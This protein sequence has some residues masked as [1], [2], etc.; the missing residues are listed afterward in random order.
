M[1]EELTILVCDVCD[2]QFPDNE[3]GSAK[4]QDHSN[5]CKKAWIRKV[6][7]SDIIP[8][9]S[10]FPF[11]VFDGWEPPVPI[12][13]KC[14][15]FYENPLETDDVGI[16]VIMTSYFLSNG[17]IT[18]YK[19]RFIY[20]HTKMTAKVIGKTTF[21]NISLIKFFY[22]THKSDELWT[23]YSIGMPASHKRILTEWLRSK[24]GFAKIRGR[25]EYMDG[26]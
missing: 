21:D 1:S 2:E 6:K 8:V 14:L 17:M 15:S 3:E 20:N 11:K 22:V 19:T 18:G 26:D 16:G 12:V 9:E 23:D 7:V 10:P 24:W 5:V 13:G 4:L 25:V